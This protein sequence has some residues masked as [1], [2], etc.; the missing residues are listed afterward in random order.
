MERGDAVAPVFVFCREIDTRRGA[1]HYSVLV[2]VTRTLQGVPMLRAA[3]FVMIALVPVVDSAVGLHR[4]DNGD[5]K[6]DLSWRNASTGASVVRLMDGAST[7]ASSVYVND[8]NWVITH[9]GDLNGD[10]KTDLVWRRQSGQ[11]A[12]WLQDGL[13]SNSPATLPTNLN[14]SVQD[15]GDLDGDGKTD[16]LWRNYA[17]GQTAAWLM[18]GATQKASTVLSSDPDWVLRQVGDFDGDG[19]ADLVWFNSTTGE[20]ARG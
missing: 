9:S 1:S 19:K 12:V 7:L 14:W 17:T 3:V 20:Q 13:S 16:L 6:S 4:N 10:G 18:N 2:D 15:V 8:P 5:A 11:T